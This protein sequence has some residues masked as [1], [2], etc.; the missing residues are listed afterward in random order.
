VNSFAVIRH[1]PKGTTSA[2]EQQKSECQR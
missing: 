1:D 2:N